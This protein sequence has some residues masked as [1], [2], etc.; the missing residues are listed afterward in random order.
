MNYDKK[1]IKYKIKYLELKHKGGVINLL[2]NAALK[3]SDEIGKNTYMTN[4]S[5][6]P[7]TRYNNKKY[8]DKYGVYTYLLKDKTNKFFNNF[9]YREKEYIIKEIEKLLL[10]KNQNHF[11]L[12]PESLL[13]ALIIRYTDYTKDFETI[14]TEI[15]NIQ[16][17]RSN[18]KL[19]NESIQII[20]NTLKKLKNLNLTKFNKIFNYYFKNLN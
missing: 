5:H 15:I 3:N 16:N 8:G 19:I 20:K 6:I 13:D 18:K 14:R 12:F 4:L 11:N 17:S 7:I 10:E 1:Y 2:Q 9:S